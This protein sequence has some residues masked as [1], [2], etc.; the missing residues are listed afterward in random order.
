[1]TATLFA[2]ALGT[3]LE[4]GHWQAAIDAVAASGG[5]RVSVPAGV[6]PVG[7]LDLRSNVELH[8]EKGAVLEGACGLE[9]YRIVTL[10]YSEGTWSAV[11]AAYGATNVAI[12]GEGTVNG[13]GER[14]P[15]GTKCPPG[16]CKEGL[17]A[18]G[19]VFADC[20]DVRLEDFTLRDAAC[21]GIVFKRCEDVV[22]RRVRIDSHANANNDG[23]DVE[24]RNVLIEDCD[25]DSGDD[26]IC[27]KSN[28]P[29]Y[30]VENVVVRRCTVRS[31]CN[32]LKLG[33][34]SHGVMRN[35]RFE[36]CRTAAPRRTFMD[37]RP[38][39]EGRPMY[40]R[41]GFDAFPA[42]VGCGAINVECVDGGVVSDIVFDDIEVD[43]FRVPIFVR[44]GERKN[45]ACGIPP[46]ARHVL[47]GV[48]IRN[49]RGRA[50]DALASS[51]TGTDRCRVRNVTFENVCL[52]CRG[53]PD[54][55]RPIA[56]PDAS[57]AGKY[58]SAHMFENLRL[59]SYG[60]Y[61]D[62]AC[63]LSLSNVVF[64]LCEGADDLRPS[65]NC[66]SEYQDLDSVARRIRIAH[67]QKVLYLGDS[68]S[69]FD[70]G[71]NHVDKLQAA[72]ERFNPGMV[73]I[74][75]FAVGGS[76]IASILAN[77]GVSEAGEPD[78][79]APR[80]AGIWDVQYDRAFVFLGQNDTKLTSV[81]GYAEMYV[82]E[83][84]QSELFDRLIALLRSKGIGRITLVSA[85]SS[86]AEVR[87]KLVA[88]KA[89]AGIPHNLFG[90]PNCLEKF[91]R[92]LQDLAARNADVD[93]LDLYAPMR[94][95]S[96][97]SVLLRP[98]D[99]VHL[100][101]L[102]HGFVAYEELCYWARESLREGSAS[103]RH[104]LRADVVVENAQLRLVLGGDATAKS[105]IV[106]ATGEEMLDNKEGRKA[107][108]VTQNRPF[109]N[110]LKL[111]FPNKETVFAANRVRRDGEFLYVG[112]E[113]VS[114][115]AKVRVD[116]SPDYVLFELVDFPLGQ[117]G[118]NDLQ[119]TYPP[120]ERFKILEI[121]VRERKYF[122]DWLNVSWDEK[123]ALAL[124]AANPYTWIENEKRAGS[125]RMTAEARRG[126]KLR[127]AKAA[128]IAS[129]TPS[130]LDAMDALERDVGLPRGVL[131]RRSADMRRSTYWTSDIL[132][133]NADEH[134]ELAKK[135][136]FSQMLI[137]YR[138]VC[139][140]AQ[141]DS[142]Y[143]GIG[144]YE[145]RDE[146]AD[147]IG[148][149]RAMLAKIK[150]AGIVPGL[151]VLQTFIGFKTH[152]VTP[153]ADPRLNLK[154]HFTLAKPLDLED[155]DVY[156]QEDPSC[157]PTNALSR[158]LVF[159][160]EMISYEGFVAARPYRFTGVKRGHFKTNV[161]PHPRGQIGGILDVCE[162]KAESCY[163]D[164][165]SDLQDEIAVKIARI[166]DAGFEFL[167]CDGSE[168]V[169]VP[170]GIH[171]GNAQYRVLKQ[172]AKPPRF[173]EG[174]AKSHFSWHHL[175]G[176]NAFDVFPPESFKQMIVR[177][178][179]HVAPIMRQDFSRVD[180]GWWRPYRPGQLVRGELTMGTQ[181]D[182]WEFGNSRAAAW[183]CPVSVQFSV[184]HMKS[185]PRWV[186]LMEVLRRWEDVRVNGK[187]TAKQKESLRSATRE[188][189]LYLNPD[190]TYD[191]FPIEM[192]PTGAAGLRG[193]V[194]E[195]NGRRVIAYW[196]MSGKGSFDIALG[197]IRRL[198]AENI[199]YLET[200]LTCQQ[201][202]RAFAA[203]KVV[204]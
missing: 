28:D 93:Y 15:M 203:A 62:H 126:L 34:A 60:L 56:S 33:T 112:F 55:V 13:R 177:W 136:G 102:G 22:A 141:G 119:M 12:T 164:Q 84:R 162:F 66:A 63:G 185:H 132:P 80:F 17:R 127:G 53:L 104:S 170:Q 10:P 18:R 11:V 82:P 36:H 105:F 199:G 32:G 57:F 198:D 98:H 47:D 40:A 44:G 173:V 79:F 204:E 50:L 81:S 200:D 158:V 108:A 101:Q 95:M 116:E 59:P 92:M 167:Y 77:L 1:M 197:A 160:G 76:T 51:V 109:N 9:H 175:S 97:K 194:F 193:F 142:G 46:G 195:R 134:I 89:A 27:I 153:V 190:G 30:A 20:R 86:D 2:L 146:Y 155:G 43:G 179:Q 87:R 118:A 149:L 157:S 111:S 140:G 121:P 180:F 49:V 26:A 110:E 165:N 172:F 117:R 156:V 186:D 24:A 139:K 69:D 73:T 72:L 201:V 3:I 39:R 135:G 31:H 65:V 5:G 41:D 130:F 42:G 184:R 48:T 202:M 196:H 152:Y 64:R 191:V 122:G 151:H 183:D 192:L 182:M 169:N 137:N 54:D 88:R 115:E 100:S 128:L 19:I 163:I 38:G 8:L 106:K 75:N 78:R 35:I 85:S 113:S 150:S 29:C 133:S 4:T 71:S 52:D 83:S 120:V 103:S 174:A 143:G 91:N 74:R 176:G 125:R 144:D 159:G 90:V 114:Y 37:R 189:H 161:V 129:A 45:R 96:D 147:D 187:L 94:A 107:F 138:S 7:Q 148:N 21:W 188:H 68:L 67:P 6:H 99:G 171:I 181:Y 58:P 168:G 145:L 123:S 166:Y 25:V 16:V 23:F 70:R 14:W 124:I 178:P 131:S 61:V 154:A